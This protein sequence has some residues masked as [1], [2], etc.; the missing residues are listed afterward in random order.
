MR[1]LNTLGINQSAPPSVW[2]G[3]YEEGKMKQP[4]GFVFLASWAERL[5]AKVRAV[6]ANAPNY[7]GYCKAESG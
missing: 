4:P 1:F 3:R 7:T 2:A 5:H 6:R